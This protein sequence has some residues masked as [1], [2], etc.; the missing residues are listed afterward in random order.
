VDTAVVVDKIPAR[1]AKTQ[2]AQCVCHEKEKEGFSCPL[3][4]RP[5]VH[6]HTWADSFLQKW[7]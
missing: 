7:I 4:F 5:L 3:S 1:A 2:A 6:R